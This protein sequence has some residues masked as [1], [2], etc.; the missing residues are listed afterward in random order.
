MTG[1]LLWKTPEPADAGQ[2]AVFGAGASLT[3][4]VVGSIPQIIVSIYRNDNM[5]VNAQTGEILWH[6]RLP[7]PVSSGMVSTPVAVGSRLFMSGFQGPGSWGICLDMQV[8]DGHIAPV[9]RTQSNRLQCNAFHT[10][11]IVDGAVYGFGLGAEQECL[12]C[13]DLDT[14][15]LLWEQA[16]PDWTRKCNLTIADGL[17]FALT[18]KEELVLAEANK[19]GYKELG[20]VNPGIKLGIPQ[21]PTLFN[22]RLYLRGIDTIVCYQA[23]Q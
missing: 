22:G 13:T 5:G 21:Q 10:V 9:T 8:K 16:G 7:T 23:A 6:W 20:R 17:I 14:G 19:T 12:Q 4:Q 15:R 18:K 11:S 2:K 3:Y 1:K